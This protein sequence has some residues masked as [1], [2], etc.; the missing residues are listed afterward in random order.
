MRLQDLKVLK[1]QKVTKVSKDLSELH[2]KE[3]RVRKEVHHRVHREDLVIKDLEGL[4]EITHKVEVVLQDLVD[5]VVIRDLQETQEPKDQKVQLHLPDLKVLRVREEPKVQKDL[6]V[7][8][9]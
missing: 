5:R 1:V 2:R 8:H 9:R 4:Q 6:R 3:L 7:I